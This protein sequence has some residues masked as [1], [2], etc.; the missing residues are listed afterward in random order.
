MQIEMRSFLKRE[1]DKR[2]V[3]G[4]PLWRIVRPAGDGLTCR[5]L[6][7]DYCNRCTKYSVLLA[8]RIGVIQIKSSR[9]Q[10]TT[11]LYELV[12]MLK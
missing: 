11:D 10:I 8:S 4:V 6:S 7:P 9:F 1:S 5:C 3:Y 2:C 12:K